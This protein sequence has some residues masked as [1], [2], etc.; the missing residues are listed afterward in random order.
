M[1]KL[2]IKMDP[3]EKQKLKKILTQLIAISERS[4]G[5]DRKRVNYKIAEL[6]KQI[7]HI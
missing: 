7:D 4:V 2:V 6:Q 5:F 3:I 1:I